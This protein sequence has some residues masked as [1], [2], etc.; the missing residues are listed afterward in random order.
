M[1][2]DCTIAGCGRCVIAKGLC[3]TH[4]NRQQRG[5]PLE[6]PIRRYSSGTACKYPGCTWMQR[7]NGLCTGHYQRS[8]RHPG[9]VTSICQHCGESFEFPDLQ[10]GGYNRQWCFTCY[11]ADDKQA[12]HLLRNFK[13]SRPE[14]SK[15]FMEQAGVCAI[16]SCEAP[17]KVVDH[18][19]TCCPTIPTCGQCTRGLLCV[20]HNVHLAWEENSQWKQEAA[21]Y[22]AC[23]TSW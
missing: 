20:T 21:D 4:Y 1:S 23:F 2:N 6:K 9:P 11:P 14:F 12:W 8:L 3:G 5:I 10:K 15:M 18:D 19:H 17:A 7:T 13:I 16:R 22:L